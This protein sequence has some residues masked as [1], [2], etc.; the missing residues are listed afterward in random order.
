MARAPSTPLPYT[1]GPKA[2]CIIDRLEADFEARH[3]GDVRATLT[4]QYF[5][6]DEP[7]DEGF[8]FVGAGEVDDISVTDGEGRPLRWERKRHRENLI[9]YFF[10]KKIRQA[11]F[12]VVLKFTMKE[13][14]YGL[15][16]NRSAVVD[17]GGSAGAE[18]RL[19]ADPQVGAYPAG[20]GARVA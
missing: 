12:T 2:P 14:L 6:Y 15:D 9:H 16:A 7:K 11:P 3:N 8:K 10:G 4:I 19:E 20:R 18:E 1:I 13:A 17:P 5:V